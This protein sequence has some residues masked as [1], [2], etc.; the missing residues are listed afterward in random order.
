[1]STQTKLLSSAT[2][3]STL[4]NNDKIVAVTE[5]GN[6][7]LV[8]S[9]VLKNTVRPLIESSGDASD[10]GKWLRIAMADKPTTCGIVYIQSRHWNDSQRGCIIAVDAPYPNAGPRVQPI[11]SGGISKMRVV[12]TV[13][14]DASPV[15]IDILLPTGY[16]Y[17]N[18]SV[19]CSGGFYAINP[20]LEPSID[21]AAYVKEFNVGGGRN[22][23]IYNSLKAV[24][25]ER[26]AA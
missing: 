13:A 21:G 25:A 14:S 4:G 10:G 16:L 11:L 8:T 6:T 18:L 5:A 22:H 20:I 23:L 3:L 12:M 9:K 26:S 24:E 7:G 15:A 1:M 2:V 17:R 19:T